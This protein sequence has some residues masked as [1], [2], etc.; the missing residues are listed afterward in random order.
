[1]HQIMPR[2]ALEVQI[3]ALLAEL[4]NTMK[5]AL[6]WTSSQP[7][8]W[9]MQSTAPFACDRMAFEHWLQ[10]LFIP[11]MSTL[12]AQAL[13]LPGKI[14]LYPMGQEMFKESAGEVLAILLKIDQRLS[15]Q[16]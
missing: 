15:E 2:E 16:H 1:M 11:K 7:S 12:I 10:F 4:E 6:L 13:A 5:I 8:D 9:A 14:A 3:D